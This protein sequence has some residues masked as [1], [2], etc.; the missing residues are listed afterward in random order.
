[1]ILSGPSG[2]AQS[3]KLLPAE[4]E[5]PISQPRHI[6]QVDQVFRCVILLLLH[7]LQGV[8]H[9][10]HPRIMILQSFLH[11]SNIQSHGRN[12]RR[13]GRFNPLSTCDNG[14]G[15]IHTCTHLIQIHVHGIHGSGEIFHVT[16]TCQDDATNVIHF[17]CVNF[18]NMKGWKWNQR[19]NDILKDVE[20]PIFCGSDTLLKSIWHPHLWWLHVKYIALTTWD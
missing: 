17:T 14:M 2:I 3:P 8:G 11:I 20:T 12:F 19:E 4:H 15:G 18:G 6:F 1:M 5:E 10:F 16:L 13:H 9:I 7:L